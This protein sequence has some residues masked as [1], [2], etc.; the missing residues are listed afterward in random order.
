MRLIER[1]VGISRA[2]YLIGRWA[3]KVPRL[4]KTVPDHGPTWTIPRAVLANQSEAQWSRDAHWSGADGVAPVLRSWLG[5]LVNVYPRC[6]EWPADAPEPVYDEIGVGWMPRDRKP[7]NVGLLNGV[8]VW[9][10]YDGS[11]NACPHE[12]NVAGLTMDDDE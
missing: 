4:V 6:E 5:G 8:P 11:W 2:V 1:R 9:L 3:I 7:Q 10:D 12:R